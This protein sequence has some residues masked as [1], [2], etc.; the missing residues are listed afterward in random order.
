M[1]G[2]KISK[3][4]M[5][6][7]FLIALSYNIFSLIKNGK[8]PTVDEQKSIIIFSSSAILFFSPI[9]LSIWL[10]KIFGKKEVEKRGGENTR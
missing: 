6:L 4:V 7:A 8:I 10:D 5:I 9:Y 1:E 3:W 2:K